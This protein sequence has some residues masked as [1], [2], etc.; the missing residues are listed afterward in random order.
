V[1]GEAVYLTYAN[2]D[3]TERT[4]VRFKAQTGAEDWK[5]TLPFS[6]HKKHRKN[7]YATATPATDGERVAVLFADQQKFLVVVYSSKGDELWRKDVGGFNAEHGSGGSPIIEGGKVY[8]TK[9]QDGASSLYAF[10]LK[11]GEK[12][13]QTDYSVKRAT[14]STPIIYR[15]PDGQTCLVCSH[16][17][18]GLAGYDLSTGKRLW[19]CDGFELRTVAMPVQTGTIVAATAGEG[20]SGKMLLAVD[21]ASSPT[22][23]AELQPLYTVQKGIP[24]CTTPVAVGSRLYF[25]TDTGIAGCLDAKTGNSLWAER[26]RGQFSA[27]PVYAH[28]VVFFLSEN[29][30]VTA[31]KPGDK[32][33]R[34]ANFHVD[35]RFLATPA[36]ADGKMYLRGESNLWCIGA[37]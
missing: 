34:L 5:R 35:D 19:K 6:T 4:L 23:D 22:G 36:V 12:A 15:G 33:E 7:T 13:W 16:S 1:S 31:I 30:D 21:L 10:D 18:T 11:T 14:Y 2:A 25:V 28:G 26:L 29:G 27:S 8:F 37:K 32:L 3:G 9:E 20:N 17:L 24:Y